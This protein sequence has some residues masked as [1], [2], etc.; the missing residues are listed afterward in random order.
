M[1]RTAK[2]GEAESGRGILNTRELTEQ[3]HLPTPPFFFLSLLPLLPLVF[4]LQPSHLHLAARL[5]PPLSSV[6][7]PFRL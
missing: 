1:R 6:P 4:F 3:I 2:V 5:L 7:T